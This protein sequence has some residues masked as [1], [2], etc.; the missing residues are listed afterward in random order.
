M[1]K[2]KTEILTVEHISEPSRTGVLSAIH[3][4][5]TR[6]NKPIGYRI[7]LQIIQKYEPCM[8]YQTI[9]HT[10]KNHTNTL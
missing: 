5:N 6:F 9:C 3:Q 7:G 2:Y 1:A 10:A 8:P 4:L